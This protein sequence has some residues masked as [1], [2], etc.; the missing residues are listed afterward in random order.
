MTYKRNVSKVFSTE[1]IIE[2]KI[3]GIIATRKKVT[4]RL[5]ENRKYITGK[6]KEKK[7][8]NKRQ[9]ERKKKK[10]EQMGNKK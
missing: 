2:E 4:I 7:R 1:S 6:I 10:K 3:Y 5:H 8:K 9:R